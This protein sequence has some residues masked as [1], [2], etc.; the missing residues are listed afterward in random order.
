MNQLPPFPVLLLCTIGCAACAPTQSFAQ[1]SRVSH[2]VYAPGS[3]AVSWKTPAQYREQLAP[4]MAMSEE[5]AIA[6]APAVNGL[7]FSPCPNCR[8]GSHEGDLTW[9]GI[10]DPHRVRCKSCGMVF[11]NDRY[12][13]NGSA[14]VR[15]RA[16]KAHVWRWHELPDGNR[17]YFLARA[18]FDAKDYLGKAVFDLA[19]A[20]RLTGEAAY[21][22]RAALLLDRLARLYPTWN[23]MHDY[24]KA[25]GKYPVE[26]AKPPFTTWNGVW[27]RWWYYEIPTQLIHAYDLLY[28]S[29][30]FEQLAQERGVSVEEIRIA[31]EEGFFRN[32][33]NFVRTYKEI[34]TNASPP[35]YMGLI[36]AGRVLGDPALVRDG[37]TR[38]ATLFR[39]QFYADGLWNEGAISYHWM[40]V[41][42]MQRVLAYARGHT[43]PANY[44]P[45]AGESRFVDLD[46]AKQ[47]PV[48]AR[49]Q[50]APMQ[51]VWP[52]GRA[53]AVHDSWPKET[54][55]TRHALGPMLLSHY[56]HA[57]LA[58]RQTDGE[59]QAHLHFSGASGHS[60]ADNLSLLLY[61]HA[62]ELL[63]DLGYTWTSW[64]FW[65]AGTPSHNTVSIDHQEIKPDRRTG[66]VTLLSLCPGDVQVIEASQ[67][68]SFD[69][70][71]EYRRRLM[72]VPVDADRSYVVD[73]FNVEGGSAHD[74]FL[75]G[76][77]ERPQEAAA[78]VTLR[79]EAD[80][81]LGPGVTFRLPHNHADRG[82]TANGWSV[83]Y[84]MIRDIRA[85]DGSAPFHVDWR[86]ADQS[87]PSLRTHVLGGPQQRVALGRSPQVRPAGEQ[88]K[89]SEEK[90]NDFW[91][92][93]LVL[94]RAGA[95][96]LASRFI[97]IH[98]PVS[99]RPFIVEIKL[100]R[101]EPLVLQVTHRA[102]TDWILADSDG[103]DVTV[104]LG[105]V[106]VTARAAL[107]RQRAA[108]PSQAWVVTSPE[109]LRGA[110]IR[111]VRDDDAGRYGVD[112][113]FDRAV[114]DDLT[115]QAARVIVGDGTGQAFVVHAAERTKAGMLLWLSN[116]P[117]FD[118][119]DAGVSY[120]FYPVRQVAGRP[121]VEIDLLRRPVGE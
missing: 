59:L 18:R 112:V 75:H 64:R 29:G 106:S 60:H 78:S 90:L 7:L 117:G 81:L 85:G 76:H 42:F 102:G 80:T 11:P 53:V 70:A 110:V 45:P 71:R 1:S 95:A 3:P 100:I 16:G 120:S 65:T 91:R 37:V 121:R 88:F 46:M 44:A 84:A 48:I 72:L 83:G 23:V 2:P 4:I 13:L 63:P 116:D 69:N 26:N 34:Y 104:S 36:A 105:E 98:E 94:R 6:L 119:S 12:P 109:R 19:A 5:Q 61:S 68:W 96:P 55:A 58:A 32:A 99:D 40:T 35:I 62:E 30:A 79:S 82:E 9:N 22:R 15:D 115:G 41:N 51:L 52:N 39:T 54:Y 33:I 92:P 10:A 43:D 67:P 21:A 31:I 14:E 118:C 50:V 107:V 87:A 97:V 47:F 74:Y 28:D 66:V 20:Y 24:P 38:A 77:A 49:S 89:E 56:G 111:T 8:K 114:S 73:V 108:R 113:V 17:S 93:T 57:R 103:D 25:G 27:A 101:E 86:F